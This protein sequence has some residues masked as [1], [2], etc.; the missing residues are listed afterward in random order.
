MTSITDAVRAG[1]KGI[2]AGEAGV[3][4]LIRQGK[5]IRDGAPWITRSDDGAAAFVDVDKLLDA[6]GVWS[7]GEYRVVQIACSLLG[8][9]PVDLSDVLSGIDRSMVVLVLAAL[10]HASGSHEHVEFEFAADGSSSKLNRP[11][12]IFAWPD[13]S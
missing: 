10:A 11:G 8:G 2:Y 6:G 5:P 7:G 4:L 3:E 13:I 9:P 1:V 12:T